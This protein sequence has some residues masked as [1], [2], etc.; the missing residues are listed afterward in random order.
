MNLIAPWQL[1]A[2]YDRYHDARLLDMARR[3][4]EW[5]YRRHV[6]DH[7]MSVVAGGVRDGVAT[8]HLWTKF[9]GGRGN[10]LPGAARANWT[11]RGG[12]NARNRAGAI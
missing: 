5:F 10:H 3:A 7:P 9:A 2:A 12:G 11:S 1:L 8:D 4:A 6:V